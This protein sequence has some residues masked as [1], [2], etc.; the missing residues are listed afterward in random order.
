MSI[1]SMMPSNLST[2]VSSSSS[3]SQYFRVFSN[4]SVLHI[5]WPTYWSFSL[6]IS[7][8]NENSGLIFLRIYWSH[9]SVQGT[10]KGL[11]Q[12]NWKA[13]ILRHSI[14]LWAT[15]TAIH[16]YWKNHSF[17]Y[18]DLSR[19]PLLRCAQGTSSHLERSL[20]NFPSGRKVGDIQG[21]TFQKM[22]EG[23]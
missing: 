18:M 21:E 1:E 20:W 14:F 16:D 8:S 10:L 3:C 19:K 2:S 4:E 9:S 23:P 17:N 6:S 15:L 22:R 12:Y 5:R 13:S 7:P 11:L